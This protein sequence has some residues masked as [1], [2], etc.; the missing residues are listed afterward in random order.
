[1]LLYVQLLLD[2]VVAV[3]LLYF[4]LL[5]IDL[6]RTESWPCCLPVVASY[7]VAASLSIS[8][9]FS[10]NFPLI[11]SHDLFF[12]RGILTIFYFLYSRCS[13]VCSLSSFGKSACYH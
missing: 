10:C 6:I 5:P 8:S 4:L 13:I 7:Q 11:K 1:M 3:V 9:S 12:C 2:A